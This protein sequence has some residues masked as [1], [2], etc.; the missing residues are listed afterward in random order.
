MGSAKNS[1]VGQ[2]LAQR[3][4]LLAADRQQFVGLRP[5]DPNAIIKGGSLLFEQKDR[6]EGHGRGVISAVAF[7]P[8]V[9]SQI[10]LALLSRPYRNHD[11]HR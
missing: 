11:Q 9:G 2:V 8:V 4:A 6:A 10:A 5:V 1:Y 7:N 3:E